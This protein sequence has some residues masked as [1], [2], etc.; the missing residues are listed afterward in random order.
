MANKISFI[1]KVL[2]KLPLPPVC[3]SARLL[4]QNYK[5][6]ETINSLGNLYAKLSR[7]GIGQINTLERIKGKGQQKHGLVYFHTVKS[8]FLSLS[9]RTHLKI[10]EKDL[11]WPTQKLVTRGV[12]Y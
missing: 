5:D 8:G 6:V 2:D 4:D 9:I 3:K 7:L 10:E 1:K 12:Q 11:S